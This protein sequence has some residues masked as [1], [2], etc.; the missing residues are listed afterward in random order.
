MHKI[1]GGFLVQERDL[2]GVDESPLEGRL[3]APADGRRR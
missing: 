3:Q 1:V 2:A